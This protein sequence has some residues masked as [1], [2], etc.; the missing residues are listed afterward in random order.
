MFYN[1]FNMSLIGRI[2]SVETI[3]EGAENA[4]HKLSVACN[5]YQKDRATGEKTDTTSWVEVLLPGKVNVENFKV[6]R[7]VLV[8]GVP[9]VNAYIDKAEGKAVGK[10]RVT[11]ARVTFQDAKPAEGAN[12][13]DANAMIQNETPAEPSND[14]DLPF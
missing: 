14:D 7:S 12:V 1:L 5:G 4:F 10:L 6:G 9:G 11:N 3:N 2:G 13:G 8:E